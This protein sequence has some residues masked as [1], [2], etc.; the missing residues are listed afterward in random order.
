MLLL[1]GTFSQFSCWKNREL[2]LL[3][4]LVYR[5]ISEFQVQHGITSHNIRQRMISKYKAEALYS[6]LTSGFHVHCSS[7]CFSYVINTTTKS[8]LGRKGFIS[9]TC[10]SHSSSLPEVREGSRSGQNDRGRLLIGLH[11]LA[12]AWPAFLC[13]LGP[14]A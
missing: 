8:N 9:F 4:P 3:C 14:L 13:N 1:P 6:A 7:L 2:S 5:Q 11:S 10:P 12:Q